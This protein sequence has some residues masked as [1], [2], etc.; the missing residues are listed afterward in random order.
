MNINPVEAIGWAGLTFIVGWLLFF[1]PPLELYGVVVL[2]YSIGWHLAMRAQ[3][4]DEEE[5]ED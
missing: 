5:E 3:A 1:H 2:V 4:P